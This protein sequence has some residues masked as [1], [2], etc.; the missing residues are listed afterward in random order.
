M[1]AM[2]KVKKRTG[3]FNR[4]FTWGGR[5]CAGITAIRPLSMP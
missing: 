3:R 2:A 4:K 5:V 1:V